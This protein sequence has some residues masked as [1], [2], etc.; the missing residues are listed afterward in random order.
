MQNNDI[1]KAVLEKIRYAEGKYKHLNRLASTESWEGV[2]AINMGNIFLN[3]GYIEI[4]Q[5]ENGKART[6][7]TKKGLAWL[8]EYKKRMVINDRDNLVE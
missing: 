5:D 7:V 1:V 8:H 2:P 6:R 4:F 3:D